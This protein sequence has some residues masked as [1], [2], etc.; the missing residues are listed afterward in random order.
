M[1]HWMQRGNIGYRMWGGGAKFSTVHTLQI[2]LFA[3]FVLQN[4]QLLDTVPFTQ[5]H[6][7]YSLFHQHTLHIQYTF[8]CMYAS[9][10]LLTSK[11]LQMR[12]AV[13]Y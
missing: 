1:H 9:L 7:K 8:V 5:S 11:S 12:L 13:K 2:L 3:D 10:C 6:E 4:S